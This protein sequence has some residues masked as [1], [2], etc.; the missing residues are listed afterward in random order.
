MNKQFVRC[1]H[2]SQEALTESCQL[3]AY[4]TV[5]DGKEYLFCCQSCAERYKT[6]NEDK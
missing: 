3:A 1:E 2:C 5:I 6:K 4:P